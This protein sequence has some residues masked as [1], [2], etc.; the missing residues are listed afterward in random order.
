MK[1]W[2]LDAD[3]EKFDRMR[4]AELE[5]QIEQADTHASPTIDSPSRELPRPTD[6]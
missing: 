5:R 3:D 1:T 6:R 2:L 4:D